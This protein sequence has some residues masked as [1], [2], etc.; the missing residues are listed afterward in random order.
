MRVL[1]DSQDSQAWFA[2]R[3]GK[4][5]A[6]C[7]HSAMKMVEKGS[8]KRGD[9]RW[10]S[11]SERKGYISELA[12]GMITRTP[13]EHYVSRAM[14]LGKQYEKMARA[15]YGFR[16]APDEQIQRT[17]FVLHPTLDYLGASP[18]GLLGKGGVELKVPQMPRHKALMETGEIPEEWVMQC[19]CN[20]LCCQQEW[21]DLASFMP[22]DEQFGQE[23]LALPHE[24]RMFRHRFFRDENIFTQ[25]EE[26]A[27]SAMEEAVEKVKRLRAMYPDKG[28]PKS[29]FVAELETSVLATELSEYERAMEVIDRVEMTP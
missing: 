1:C 16:F 24:F 25:M 10:E 9:K 17:G 26:G 14:D 8:K 2:A 6:S 15:E 7:I 21:W 22:A 19:Y 5:T 20:M 18:D 29:K 27:T 11:S 4:V 12:W 13:V 3:I 28:A 23:A